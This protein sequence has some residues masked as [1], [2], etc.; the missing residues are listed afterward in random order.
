MRWGER[1]NQI[2][3]A[4]RVFRFEGLSTRGLEDLW[5]LGRDGGMERKRER[6][7]G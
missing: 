7:K 6:E 4:L 2:L 3:D 5:T 1:E